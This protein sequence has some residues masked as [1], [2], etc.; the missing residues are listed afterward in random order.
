MSKGH[1]IADVVTIIGTQ[2]IV[3]V[4]SSGIYM[5]EIIKLEIFSWLRFIGFLKRSNSDMKFLRE[6]VDGYN[7]IYSLFIS[8]YAMIDILVLKSQKSRVVY[9]IKR[10]TKTILVESPNHKLFE[11]YMGNQNCAR[12][13]FTNSSVNSNNR[14]S[15]GKQNNESKQKC[16][17]NKIS[18]TNH[19]IALYIKHNR[20]LYERIN[21]LFSF[22]ASENNLVSAWS[23]IKSNP[24]ILYPGN[25]FNK[26]IVNYLPINCLTKAS[27]NLLNDIYIYKRPKHIKIFKNKSRRCSLTIFTLLDLIIQKAFLK[28]LE[29]VFQRQDDCHGM[30][31]F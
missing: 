19:N 9:Q 13:T 15:E 24:G 7:I 20:N 17:T 22:I 12:R 30:T 11:D 2:D 4:R 27:F 23:N 28:V 31:D 1:L 18:V 16:F 21:N 25:D 10:H 8:L 3:F 14:K 5:I 6:K 29:V 26:E